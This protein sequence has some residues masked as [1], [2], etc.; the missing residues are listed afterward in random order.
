M[1]LAVA[2][3]H[4]SLIA[5]RLAAGRWDGPMD[6]ARAGLCLVCVIFATLKLRRIVTVVDS[7]P[8]GVMSV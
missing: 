2:V 5:A 8:L 3:L 6:Y 4:G 1:W 7:E